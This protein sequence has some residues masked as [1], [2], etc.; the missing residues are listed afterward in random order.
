M[1]NMTRKMMKKAKRS[2]KKYKRDKILK[3]WSKEKV[4]KHKRIYS[5]FDDSESKKFVKELDRELKFR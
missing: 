3:T 2:K 1:I 5:Q 4:E